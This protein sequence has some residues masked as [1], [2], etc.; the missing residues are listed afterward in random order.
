MKNII[1]LGSGCARCIKTAELIDK[2]AQEQSAEVT[3]S[4]ETNPETIM[5]YGVMSTPA[6]V[7]DNALVHSGSIPNRNQ[8]E[9]WLNQ[10]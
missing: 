7:I 4:K 6:V 10:G 2:I 1:V 3:V 9:A 5:S 8:I